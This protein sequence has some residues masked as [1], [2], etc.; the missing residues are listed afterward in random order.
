M[1]KILIIVICLY[2]MLLTACGTS[3]KEST[4]SNIIPTQ[5]PVSAPT[6]EPT[7]S[8]N[9]NIL[10]EQADFRNIKWGMSMAEVKAAEGETDL[11]TTDAL[12]YDGLNVAGIDVML[13]YYFNENDQLYSAIYSFE[14]THVNKNDYIYDYEK[15][16]KALTEK[17]GE[18]IN[19]DTIW[20]D[21]LYK[22]EPT[23]W[24]MAVSAGHMMMFAKW[25]T[26][27]TNIAIF[28][29]GDNFEIS[30]MIGYESKTIPPKKT[31]ITEG[32]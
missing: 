2:T 16:V 4:K 8:P 19:S 15:V 27:N 26:E 30:T 28:L 12:I 23:E 29:S 1:K 17:Y 5:K 11:V 10:P 22:D 20:K 32:L 21:D 25:E 14:E 13:I 18:P 9:Q 24:G 7:Q 31:D 3:D 6:T